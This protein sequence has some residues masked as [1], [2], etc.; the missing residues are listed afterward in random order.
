MPWNEKQRGDVKLQDRILHQL[1]N[2]CLEATTIRFWSLLLLES[3]MIAKLQQEVHMLFASQTMK[4]RAVH[5][6][7]HMYVRNTLGVQEAEL[8]A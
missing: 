6:W 5:F 7:L 8:D 2:I 1:C 3:T 4:G